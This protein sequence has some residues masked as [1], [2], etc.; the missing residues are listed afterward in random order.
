[1]HGDKH[2]LQIVDGQ[3]TIVCKLQNNL[4][5]M[6]SVA[7]PIDQ[8]HLP[9]WFKE[10]PFDIETMEQSI[11]DAKLKNLLGVLNWDYSSKGK[12]DLVN[13]FFS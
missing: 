7:Y 4:L 3:K 10:L 12:T 6:T 1:M 13:L 8:S 11:I 2:S 9:G 5:G